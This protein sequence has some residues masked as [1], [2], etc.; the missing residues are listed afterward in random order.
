VAIRP[1]I[2]LTL[3][4]LI[5][6]L[7]SSLGRQTKPFLAA[8]VGKAYAKVFNLFWA[9]YTAEGEGQQAAAQ[10]RLSRRELRVYATV[11]PELNL[12][13]LAEIIWD[14]VEELSSKDVK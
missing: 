3:A 1:G 10:P 12:D 13:K 11:R 9:A 4:G 14:H 6:M 5:A 8:R 2:A 7:A